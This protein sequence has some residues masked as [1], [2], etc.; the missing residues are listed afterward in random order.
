MAID[1][2]KKL[3]AINSVFP[4]EEELANFLAD[5]LSDRDFDVEL[6][7]FRGRYNVL[8]KKG[9]GKLL[10]AGHMDT[11]PPYQYERDPLELLEQDGKLFG[12]GAYDM[13]A[14]LAAILSSCDNAD[15]LKVMFVSDEENNSLGTYHAIRSG[16]LKGVE[17]ALVPEVSDINDPL[18][19]TNTIMLGRRGRAQYELEV[20]GKSYHAAHLD[21]GVSAISEASKIALAIERM[22][23]PRH[24]ELISGNQFVREM[25]SKSTSLSIP[26]KAR[27]VIDRHLVFPES[28]ESARADIQRKIDELVPDLLVKPEVR[29]VTREVPYLMPY[30]TA[31]ENPYVEKLALSIE[32]RLG[33]KAEYNY[34]MSVADENLIAMQGIPVA[35]YGPIGAGEH[36]CDEWVSKQS[37][38]E[39]VDVMRDY[40]SSF[41]VS[42]QA[43][44]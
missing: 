31:K 12:L 20:S 35:S 34:G 22:D 43:I 32:R 44:E 18:K 40:M 28:V 17:F 10:L 7:D 15:S 25:Q 39:L 3:V 38:L 14:G 19:K 4:E 29:A 27:L 41:T 5:Q 23:M 8:A 16:F 36:S 2:L 21:K 6:Q 33:I 37:Y 1:L 11:V 13:K 30:I 9:E 26:E 24:P 42:K